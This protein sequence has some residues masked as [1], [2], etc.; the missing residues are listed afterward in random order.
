MLVVNLVGFMRM[1]RQHRNTTDHNLPVDDN[2]T[3]SSYDLPQ[4][5]HSE[6]EMVGV[7]CYL[8]A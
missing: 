7:F 3:T 8:A 4:A 1:S 2:C 6:V 5:S